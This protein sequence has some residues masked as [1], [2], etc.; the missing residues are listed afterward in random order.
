M[1]IRFAFPTEILFGA[2][3]TRE[4]AAKLSA[5]GG[6][7]PLIVTDKGLVSTPTFGR[8]K[9]ALPA[10]APVFSDV[11]SNPSADNVEA[12]IAAFTQ[13]ACDSVIG[14]GGGSAIDVAK[15]VR[16]RIKLPEWKLTD[17]PPTDN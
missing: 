13:N 6:K 1:A 11:Q 5:L 7:R 8:A 12:A 17:P 16:L 15:V 2:G 10:D 9:A 4:A 3:S 14:L